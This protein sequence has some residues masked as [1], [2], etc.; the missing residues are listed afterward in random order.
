MESKDLKPFC[1]ANRYAE[2]FQHGKEYDVAVYFH[3]SPD[4]WTMAED[5]SH[6]YKIC[7][8]YT[9]D[10]IIAIRLQIEGYGNIVAYDG[11]CDEIFLETKKIY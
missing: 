7:M 2:P 6:E 1:V 8:H 10:P 5:Q 9:T 11:F 4:E 3:D